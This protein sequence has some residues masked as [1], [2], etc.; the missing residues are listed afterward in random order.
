MRLSILL[1][2]CAIV[3]CAAVAN[4]GFE[5]SAAAA[6]PSVES[7]F[8][9]S[10]V[11]GALLSPDGRLV[12]LRAANKEH[13]LTLAVLNLETM[14]LS[15]VAS[16]N[17]G[18]VGEF[19]WVNEHRLV[20]S[21]ADLTKGKA[22]VHVGPGLFAVNSD[23]SGMRQLVERSHYLVS[24]GD[25]PKLLPWRT[26][27]LGGVGARDGNDVFAVQVEGYGKSVDTYTT[28]L[29]LNT[30]NGRAEPVEVPLHAVKWLIDDAGV[31]RVVVSEEG[32]H[33]IV[34]YRD[35]AGGQWR[36]LTQFEHYVGA[37]LEPVYLAPDDTLYVRSYQGRD[38]SAIYRYDLA[39][40]R[41][42]PQPVA[43]SDDFDVYPGFVHNQR[44]L[45]GLRYSIDAEI[46]Q[47][48]DPAMA[49]LQ[50]Q[51]DALLPVTT[52]RINVA[53]RAQTPYV[54]VT[55]FSDAQPFVYYVYNTATQK[56][57][58]LGGEHADIDVKQMSQK[59]FIRYRA[60][61]GLSIP[62]YITTPVGAPKKPLPM[63]VMVHGGPYLRGG[64]WNWNPETQFLASRGYVVL[65]PE[66]RG[67]TGYGARHFQA[68]WKQ[69]GLGM[70][71]DIADAARW[72]IAQGIAD[73][74]RICIAGA[75]YGGYATLMGL[76]N[77]PD[78][79]RCGVDWAGVTDINLMYSVSWSDASDIYKRHGMPILIGDR[80][81]DAAQ[82][83]AT[84]PLEQA[85][86]IKQPLLLAYG[87]ADERVPL[88]HGEKFYDA[89]KAGNPDVE[90]ITYE[91][92][93]HGWEMVPDRVDFW[94]R[95]DKFL[96]K[97]IGAPA[98]AG[99]SD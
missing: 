29:R 99:G 22:D 35:T 94:N 89:V 70:Q 24:A 10:G 61:D 92:E 7:F 12:A 80:V 25:A 76:V 84:S 77:D 40:D 75:S 30:V 32:A 34:R 72:A 87:G 64:F 11:N 78:L 68:G 20:F 47:W 56:L 54:M 17:D 9:N 14:K 8:Q 66:F 96:A 49:A 48:L 65:E 88:V 23:G 58:K 98:A 3:V 31:P 15:P 42:L 91:K 74:K 50:K 81:K 26:Y 73:P 43:A 52:N 27:L 18:D 90:W 46:T 79:F 86:R 39:H 57:L 53:L 63:V 82:L 1:R 69:W 37:E 51:I 36:V 55:A 83:Q 41:V 44:G 60:R 13:R 38:K 71:N 2:H 45:L 21:M 33:R 6:L 97:H 93:G 4:I 16:Y 28:L 59:D 5:G 67:S 19:D 85:A 62:A 95:V